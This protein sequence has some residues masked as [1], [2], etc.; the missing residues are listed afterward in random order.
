MVI[1]NWV[2]TIL[3]SFTSE[4]M[5]KAIGIGKVFL[6]F[7]ICTIIFLAYFYKYMI[8]SSGKSRK[9]LVE[10]FEQGVVLE[11]GKEEESVSILREELST[12]I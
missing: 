3:V 5:I 8:E 1:V 4:I 11:K 12:N 9:E 10:Q 7:G 6:M 2:F